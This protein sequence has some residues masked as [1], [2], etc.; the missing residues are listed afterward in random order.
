[1]I[2]DY[3]DLDYRL[4]YVLDGKIK[5]GFRNSDSKGIIATAE[6]FGQYEFMTEQARL[7]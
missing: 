4:F 1:M 5:I 3:A 2:F 7:A 6:N